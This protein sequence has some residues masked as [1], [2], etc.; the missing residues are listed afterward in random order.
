MRNMKVTVLVAPRLQSEVNEH[1]VKLIEVIDNGVY[2]SYIVSIEDPKPPFR[3]NCFYKFNDYHNDIG[4]HSPSF[5]SPE[6]VYEVERLSDGG[7]GEPHAFTYDGSWEAVM[8]SLKE[9]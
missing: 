8:C 7:W 6:P 5:V 2:R 3:P 9:V 4:I 1:S